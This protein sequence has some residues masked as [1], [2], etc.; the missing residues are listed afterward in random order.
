MAY[1]SLPASSQE[2]YSIEVEDV[3]MI[4]NMASEVLTNLKEYFIKAMKH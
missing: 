2:K 3:S 4:F 1:N